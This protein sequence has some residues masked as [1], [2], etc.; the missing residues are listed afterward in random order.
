MTIT[1]RRSDGAKDRRRV[2]RGGRR[3][4]DQPG[5]FPRLLVAESY[6]GVREP[7]V[8]YL[9]KFGFHVDEAATG[10]I[11]LAKIATAPPHLILVESRLPGAPVSAIMCQLRDGT[12][13]PA[14][15]IIAMTSDADWDSKGVVDEPLVSVIVK[16]FSLST[17]L[18]EV[19]RLLREQPPVVALG[20]VADIATA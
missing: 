19:R 2:A 11:A 7:C 18:E 16:P 10:E 8:R 9:N 13:A 5:R 20:A 12:A 17:M 6:D 4:G 1:E 14:I 15:P 3:N